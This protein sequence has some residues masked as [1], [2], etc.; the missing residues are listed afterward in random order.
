MNRIDSLQ[1]ERKSLRITPRQLQKPNIVHVTIRSDGYNQ[2]HSKRV[3]AQVP[4]LGRATA[5]SECLEWRHVVMHACLV[6]VEHARGLVPA[7]RAPEVCSE[8]TASLFENFAH[9][10][11]INN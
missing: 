4:T 1:L 8:L 6:D 3:L 10:Y 2:C 11:V 7:T 9:F 5:L